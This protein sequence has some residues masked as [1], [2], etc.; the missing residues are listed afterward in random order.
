[1]IFMSTRVCS[2]GPFSRRCGPLRSQAH[3][4]SACVQPTDE[5]STF[6]QLLFYHYYHIFKK[7]RVRNGTE[8]GREKKEKK[9]TINR[10]GLLFHITAGIFPCSIQGSLI[11][12]GELTQRDVRGFQ[13]CF[14]HSG[15]KGSAGIWSHL[16]KK[17]G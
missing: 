8:K 16:E 13:R 17:A 7:C 11:L 3:K 4:L 12:A 10:S 2:L 14:L 5:R 9:K 6:F 1:M 15:R